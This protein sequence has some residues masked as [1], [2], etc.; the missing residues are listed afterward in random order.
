MFNLDVIREVSE[1]TDLTT[2]GF[3]ETNQAIFNEEIESEL[4]GFLHRGSTASA[5]VTECNVRVRLTPSNPSKRGAMWY[6][7]QVPVFSGFETYFTFQISDHS[8]E[9]M[10]STYIYCVLL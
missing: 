10:Y 5:P 8:K 4:A 1:L 2:E 6:R 7:E 9:C 3:T